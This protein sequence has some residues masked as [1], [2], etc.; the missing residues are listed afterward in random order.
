MSAR[1][2]AVTGPAKGAGGAAGNFFLGF[3]DK[4]KGRCYYNEK[5]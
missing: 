4:E 2:A 5:N 3:L 1:S